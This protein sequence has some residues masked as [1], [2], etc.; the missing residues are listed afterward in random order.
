MSVYKIVVEGKDDIVFLRRLIDV[1]RGDETSLKWQGIQVHNKVDIRG[2]RFGN[3]YVELKNDLVA[4]EELRGVYIGEMSPSLKLVKTK[5]R[6]LRVDRLVGIFDADSETNFLGHKVNHGGLPNRREYIEQRFS[7]WAVKK[8]FFFMPDDDKNGAME[9]LMLNV[10]RPEYRFIIE[11]NWPAYRHEVKGALARKGIRSLGYGAKCTLSQF[12]A[13]L[14]EEV[15]KDLYWLDSL[16]N[17]NLWDWDSEAL[18]PL[19]AFL[20][21][22]VPCLFQRVE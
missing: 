13:I 1:I 21:L 11:N 15:A 17:D 7:S 10:I 14:D 19:R 8:K 20:I 5:N 12:S 6:E 22:E 2:T 18:Q 16:F 3:S 4:I 9:D